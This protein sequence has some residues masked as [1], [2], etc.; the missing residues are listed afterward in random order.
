[1]KSIVLHKR[2]LPQGKSKSQSLVMLG[3]EEGNAVKLSRNICT[4]Y[5]LPKHREIV[6]PMVLHLISIILEQLLQEWF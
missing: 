5:Y 4:T 6:S 3:L 2:K 1:M